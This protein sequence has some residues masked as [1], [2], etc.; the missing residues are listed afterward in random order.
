LARRLLDDRSG[1]LQREYCEFF[2]K[3]SQAASRRSHEPLT[4]EEF[5]TNAAALEGARLAS[6]AVASVWRALHGP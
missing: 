6:E 2:A 4:S 5:A 3:C 1:A